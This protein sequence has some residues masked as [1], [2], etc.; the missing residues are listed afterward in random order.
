MKALAGDNVDEPILK[1]L[2]IGRLPNST[3]TIL[4]ALGEDLT[5]LATVAG[6]ISDLTNHSNINAVHVTVSTSDARVTQLE[7]QVA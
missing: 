5:D 2:W 1:S 4:A 6:K 7:Q 3:H